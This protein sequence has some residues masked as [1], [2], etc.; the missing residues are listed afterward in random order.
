L[1]EVRVISFRWK[2]RPDR[3]DGFLRRLARNAAGNTA[4]IMAAALLP[5]AGFTGAA[6]DTA[7]L[8]VV[9]VRL[10]Q[11]CD[12]GALAGRKMMTG[13]ALAQ[14]DKD[15]AK[16]FFDNNFR[17]GWFQTTGASFAAS[18]TADGQVQG[19][20][21][22]T[23]PVTIMRIFGSNSTTLNVTCEARK[24]IGDVDVMFVL[25]TTGSMAC[26]ATDS[27]S[28]CN[29]YDVS[30]AVKSGGI[31]SVTEKSGSRISALRGA[32][33]TFYDT[34]AA[35]ADT[36]SRIRYGVVP[37]SS[38][39]NLGGGVLPAS[40]IVDSATYPTRSYA[41]T[42]SGS[43]T[44][45][46]VTKIDQATC[47]AKNGR[48]PA[49]GYPATQT[50]ATW[51]SAT[52]TNAPGVCTVKT[53]ARVAN[54]TYDDITLDVSSYKHGNA[55]DNP[56]RYDSAT[57]TW[58]G[59]I[60]ERQTTGSTSFSQSSLPADLDINLAPTSDATKW[61]PAW[62]DVIYDRVSKG[63]TS[64]SDYWPSSTVQ[65]ARNEDNQFK[66]Q[67]YACPK[68]AKRL[69]VMTRQDL[70]DFVSASNGFRPQ[71]YTYHDI[72]MIWGARF[73]SPNGI[74]AADTDCRPNRTCGRHIVFMTDGYMNPNHCAYSAQGFERLEGRVM[75]YKPVGTCTTT[76][77]NL[78]A[79]GEP[80]DF[81]ARHN[82]RFLAACTQAK[83]N[84]ITIWVV[85]YAQALTT[86]LT[87]CASSSDTAIYA[88]TDQK[89]QDAFKQIAGKIAEL[90][91][92]K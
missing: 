43:I 21:S 81:E 63:E 35:A 52:G 91:I 61:K 17:S 47:L 25:D 2:T 8:Y 82:A 57:S 85:A 26:L 36:N 50:D 55:V 70:S 13:T 7:R 90:R 37:Y 79:S 88:P 59:C 87:Q 48:S 45:T 3:K 41:D 16:L 20:A 60:L 31:W 30:N 56:S 75:G 46:S 67:N 39:V 23:V 86:E 73:L 4:A 62:L 71:G 51:A 58:D 32:V 22:V 83:N 5:L 34:L 84:G 66:Y 28:T 76:S 19:S 54:Y 38:S 44:T 78:S 92:S 6:V 10:Q 49:T 65:R 42:P 18:D 40:Y 68:R 77:S 69:S 11:A 12:A 80:S 24:E 27:E 1:L 9:K 74:F 15:R 89:L 53:Q 29:S 33:L 14:S 72:G 64:T